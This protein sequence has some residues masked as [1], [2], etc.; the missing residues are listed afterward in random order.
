MSVLW[1]SIVGASRYYERADGSLSVSEC[2]HR[3]YSQSALTKN[4]APFFNLLFLKSTHTT[5]PLRFTVAVFLNPL[6]LKSTG[7]AFLHNPGGQKSTQSV[8][9][10]KSTQTAFSIHVRQFPRLETLRIEMM[11]R[12]ELCISWRKRTR[13]ATYATC[14]MEEASFATVMQISLSHQKTTG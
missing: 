13:R 5:P 7:A 14:F 12:S 10:T 11:R 2:T 3:V 8:L 9:P 4:P 1:E 6:S